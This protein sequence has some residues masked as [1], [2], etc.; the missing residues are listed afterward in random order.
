[1]TR[2]LNRNFNR[3]LKCI[4]KGAASTVIQRK[5]DD[6]IYHHYCALLENGTKPPL[7]KPTIARQIASIALGL[8]RNKEEY[9]P[10][11]L[12]KE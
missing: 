10:S 7:A 12:N 3:Q 5:K 2:G 11:R 1:M 9:N 6:P 4:F 8:W